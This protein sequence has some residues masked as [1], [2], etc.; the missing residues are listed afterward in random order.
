MKSPR[1]FRRRDRDFLH[2]LQEVIEHEYEDREFGLARLAAALEI[3]ER[4]VQ[5]KLKSLL[6]CTLSEYL[7]NYRLEKALHL[8]SEGEPV[9]ETASRIGFA[10]PSYFTSCFR[11]RYGCTPTKYQVDQ[12]LAASA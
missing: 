12:G 10:S 6:A 7:R 11:A 5:R 1:V 9:G 3:S 2:R 8:L 4:Q